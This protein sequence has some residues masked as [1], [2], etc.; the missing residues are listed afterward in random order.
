MNVINIIPPFT[1]SYQ[2]SSTLLTSYIP[3]YIYSFCLQIF[4]IIIRIILY[5]L[6]DYSSF[7]RTI[8]TQLPGIVWPYHWKLPPSYPPYPSSLLKV[9]KII[10]PFMNNLMILVTFGV[11]SPLLAFVIILTIILSGKHWLYLIGRFFLLRIE[12]SM[13]LIEPNDHDDHLREGNNSIH[14]LP[15][16]SLSSDSF[17]DKEERQSKVFY[18]NDDYLILVNSILDK[19]SGYYSIC[20]WPILITSTLFFTCLSWDMAGDRV[21]WQG[22]IWVPI[23]GSVMIPLFWI[24]NKIA[25]YYYLRIKQSAIQEEGNCVVS[26]FYSDRVV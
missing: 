17:R 5:S 19:T 6:Y 18:S 14:E 12:N 25:G 22:A 24:F 11:C 8:L 2:C 1:Y 4:E 26:S 21:G 23:C 15:S 13:L 9:D 16:L 10:T 20:L 7:P 3:V